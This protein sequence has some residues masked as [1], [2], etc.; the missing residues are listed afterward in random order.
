ML[1]V[2]V[3]R[4]RVRRV[5]SLVVRSAER[6]GTTVAMEVCRERSVG[7]HPVDVE[8]DE[9]L[10]AAPAVDDDVHTSG[11][12]D[13]GVDRVGCVRRKAGLAVTSPDP[14][15]TMAPAAVAS[16]PTVTTIPAPSA[17]DRVLIRM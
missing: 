11:R 2:G 12:A 9:R 15:A 3:C 10:P 16:S 5:G 6:G 4:N 8:R 14:L 1:G 13:R 17:R 7:R